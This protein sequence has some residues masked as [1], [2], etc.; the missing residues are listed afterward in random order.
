MEFSI[1]VATKID[2]WQLIQYAEQLG[3]D[4]AWVPDSQMIWSDCYAT[5]ALA[6][7]NTK[8]I[9]LGTGV[10]IPGTRI[11]PV[12]A[13]SIASIAR[14][15]PGRVFLGIGTGHTAMRVMGMGPMRIKDFREYLRVIRALLQGEEVEYTLDGVT[16]TLRFLHQDLDFINIR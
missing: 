1:T 8:R 6:A 9:R 16:R 15:A 4:R 12:T 10:A 14:L 2:N 5:L 11:A 3:Y 7:H 13:H